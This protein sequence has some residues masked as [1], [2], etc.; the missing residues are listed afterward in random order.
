MKNLMSLNITIQPLYL[1]MT[2]GASAVK[3]HFT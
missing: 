2:G 1:F 3:L